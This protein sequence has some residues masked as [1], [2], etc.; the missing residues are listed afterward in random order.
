MSLNLLTEA[1]IPVRRCSGATDLVAPA[2]LAATEPDPVAALEWPRPDFRLACIEWL[3]G[4]LATACPPADHEAWLDWWNDPPDSAAL[5]AAFAPLAHAFELDGDGPRFLQDLEDFEAEPNPAEALLIEAPGDNTLKRN[6]DLL[7][8]RSR[9][10]SLARAAAAMALYTL[11]AYAPSGGAGNRTGLRGGGPLTTLVVPPAEPGQ[12]AS[13]WF[14]IW[15]NVP[16][17]EPPAV[18]NLP[19]VFPWLAPT[20]LS[21][22]GGRATTPNDVHP[23]Q[24][25]WGMPRRI[26]LDFTPNPD[27][28]PCDVTG[29]VDQIVVRSWRQRPWGVS[30]Q[31]WQHPLTPHYRTKPTEPLLPVHPQPGGIGYQHWLGLVAEA[32][33]RTPAQVVAAYR[34]DRWRDTRPGTGRPWR[35]LAGGYDMDNMKARGFAESEMPVPEPGDPQA[36]KSQDELAK[37]LVNAANQVAGLLARCVRRAIYGQ[38]AALDAAPLAA[39]RDRFWAETSGVFFDLLRQA[40]A[41]R[42]SAELRSSWRAILARDARRLFDEA[43]PVDPGGEG[44]PKR[45]ADAAKQ[46]GLALAGYGKEGEALFKSLHLTLPDAARGQKRHSK[47]RETT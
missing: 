21:D 1:W 18:E 25:W 37:A 38:D 28:V 19:A 34:A 32:A 6:A 36:A 43:A 22:K 29:R 26:R 45:I 41:G 11:Q 14:L 8:K 23:L 20:R 39:L 10:G 3:V 12:E 35:L 7:V 42:P 30:Y 16:C 47:Q 4:L 24:V 5:D 33:E 9:I 46:L 27:A 13:L 40:A 17:G 44:H 31:L 15:A 2:A